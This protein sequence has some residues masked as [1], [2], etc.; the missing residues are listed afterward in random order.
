MQPL[1]R[2]R[3][4]IFEGLHSAR[5]GNRRIHRIDVRPVQPGICRTWI[6]R[7]SVALGLRLRL[8]LSVRRFP[9]GENSDGRKRCRAHSQEI[10]S[11]QLVFLCLL[12]HA[13]TFLN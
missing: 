8:I 7:A 6:A 12:F 5:V 3:K 4:W 1:V 11:R 9:R 2:K 13:A 10:P